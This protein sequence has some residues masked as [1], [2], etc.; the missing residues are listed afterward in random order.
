[1]N[2]EVQFRTHKDSTK[3]LFWA[4]STQFLVLTPIS[5]GSILILSSHPRLVLSKGLFHLGLSVKIL[6]PLLPS[7]I[8]ATLPGHLKL[9]DLSTI[10]LGEWYKLWSFSLWNLLHSPF[11]FLLGSNIR[12]RILFSNTL[13]LYSSLNVRDHVWKSYNTNG[14]VVVLYNF[15]FK[16]LEKSREDKSIWT[17]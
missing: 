1:M 9:L 3:C 4:E 5:L 2:A 7:P 16:F 6:K 10:V 13:S 11:A 17:E 12:I 14:N 8:L 15:I